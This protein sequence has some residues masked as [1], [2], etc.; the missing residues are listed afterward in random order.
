LLGYGNWPDSG[1]IDIMEYVG[2]PGWTSAALH[3]PGYSGN[4]PLTARQDFPAGTNVTGWHEYSVVR[5]ADSVTFFVDDRQIYRVTR[6]DVERHGAWRFDRAQYLILNFALGGSYP[7]AVNGISAPY[8]GLPQSTAD[9][10]ARG[11]VSMEV[12]WVRVWS[13]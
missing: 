4:T 5:T 2:V 7:Q 1:E 13:P 11:E 10:V 12:D 6:P 3:G 9:A 8:A